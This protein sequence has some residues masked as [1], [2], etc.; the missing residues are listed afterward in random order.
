M[1]E[2]V[3][4]FEF[5]YHLS[6]D[7]AIFARDYISQF[8]SPDPEAA[9]L[10]SYTV[11]SLYFDTPHLS[12]YYDKGGGFLVRKKL[13]ARI[14][15]DGLT[16]E[17]PFIFLE[18]KKKYDMAFLKHRV[19][20]TQQEWNMIMS[21]QFSRVLNTERSTHA[22]KDLEAFLFLL[23]SEGRTPQYFIRYARAPFVSTAGRP[24][25]ITFDSLIEASAHDALTAPIHMSPT[26]PNLTVL[27]VKFTDSLPYWFARLERD[28]NLARSTFSKYANGVDATKR[29]NPLPQ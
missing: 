3:S 19:R 7:D 27:E 24:I 2:G 22:K 11:S 18:V 15:G 29:F 17:T 20:I 26:Y 25:R 8:L 4:R 1:F 21:G 28:L 13:R 14:Y 12:D 10:G 5:K 23:L 16:A 6:P 9:P